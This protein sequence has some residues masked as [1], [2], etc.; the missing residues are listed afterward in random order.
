LRALLARELVQAQRD[1]LGRAPVV[2]EHDRRVVRLH[3]CQQLRIDGRPDRPARGLPAGERL[4][5]GARRQ[6]IG[7]R[8]D[9]A[10]GFGHRLDRH[11]DAQVQ[12]LAP[13][14]V[15]DRHLALRAD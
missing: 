11:L 15:D 4:G 14:G 7:R 1:A 9:R 2:D 8:V 12:A 3:L 13:A 6:R 5:R 10:V